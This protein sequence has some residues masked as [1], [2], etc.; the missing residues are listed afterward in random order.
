MVYVASVAGVKDR[1]TK[2]PK[3]MHIPNIVLAHLRSKDK[4]IRL[5]SLTASDGI[6]CAE[7]VVYC[8]AERWCAAEPKPWWVALEFDCF[9]GHRHNTRI[10]MPD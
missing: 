3:V 9:C 2:I 7:K 4:R 8:C 1:A 6:C 10:K 5:V